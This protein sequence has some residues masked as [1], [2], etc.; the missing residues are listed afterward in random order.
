MADSLIPSSYGK[1]WH[2][3]LPALTAATSLPD[4]SSELGWIGERAMADS[5]SDHH[6]EYDEADLSPARNRVRAR[7]TR[8]ALDARFAEI[9][10]PFT[11][12]LIPL[13]A[14]GA[15]GDYFTLS[16]AALAPILAYDVALAIGALALLA[17]VSRGAGSA[18]RAW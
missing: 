5:R 7:D 3:L 1:H 18:R 17:G 11:A 10:R 15:V 13:L 6:H 12:V 8:E 14:V 9:V 16:S 2:A 4:D